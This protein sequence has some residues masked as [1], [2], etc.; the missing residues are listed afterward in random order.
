M[1]YT[2][3]TDGAYSSKRNKGGVGIVFLKNDIK[4]L[5]YSQAFNNTTNNQMELL[6]VLIG[7]KFI[8]KPIN[9]L[10]IITDSMYVI[11]CAIKGWKRKKNI[12]LWNKFDKEYNRVR[13]MCPNIT[14]KHIKGHTGDKWNTYC[15]NLA[16]NASK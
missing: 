13:E 10:L 4:I 8:K 1:N 7:L 9:N 5:E 14:F 2:L 6:A 11:G 15:D 16:V 3:I 12:E